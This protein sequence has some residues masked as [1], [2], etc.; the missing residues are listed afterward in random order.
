MN[1]YGS[2]DKALGIYCLAVRD[3]PA[4]TGVENGKTAVINVRP[5]LLYVL[6]FDQISSEYGV[7]YCLEDYYLPPGISL[8]QL[9][10]WLESNCLDSYSGSTAN[11]LCHL[12][13]V[14]YP[15]VSQL[16]HF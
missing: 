10:L 1:A 8:S 15:L 5:V 9:S 13:N 3:P 11:L 14:T 16:P 2:H 4:E 6:T 7:S 12:T